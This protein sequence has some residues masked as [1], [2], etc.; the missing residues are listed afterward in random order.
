MVESTRFASLKSAPSNDPSDNSAPLKFCLWKF[1]PS[2]LGKQAGSACAAAR[3]AVVSDES[4]D[5]D[6]PHPAAS[7]VA[8]SARPATMKRVGDVMGR[9]SSRQVVA[10]DCSRDVALRSRP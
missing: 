9:V 7:A 8:A 1:A 4:G 10:H 6:P 2:Q 3:D 5:P